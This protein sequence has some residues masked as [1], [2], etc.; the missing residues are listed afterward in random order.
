M[1]YSFRKW[2]VET[3]Q[4]PNKLLLKL[5]S[6]NLK[7]KK[8]K[9]IKIIGLCYNLAEDE[10]IDKA[11]KYLEETNDGEIDIE[12]NEY[13]DI[14][15]EVLFNRYAQI[16]EPIII[17]FEN[18]DKLEIDYCDGSSLKIGKNSLPNDINYG[19]NMPNM[20][21]NILFSNCI[22]KEILGYEVSMQDEFELT[23][24]FTGSHGIDYPEEN[25]QESFISSFK[26]I[27]TNQLSIEFSNFFDYGEVMI[28]ENKNDYSKIKWSDLKKG[29]KRNNNE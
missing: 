6:F 11:F 13:D 15:D 23:Y 4:E 1:D 22:D 7:G 21:G 27:L 16:D 2:N 18:G 5:K 24:D 9:N 19:C 25:K 29:I 12:L 8:I 26:I 17:E 3:I 20:D 10:T 14:P 28:I